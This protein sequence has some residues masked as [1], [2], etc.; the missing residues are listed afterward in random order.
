MPAGK[1][2]IVPTPIGNLADMTYRGVEILRI[3]SLIG[4]EDTR[5]SAILL[6]HYGIT[7][8]MLSY[9]KFNEKSRLEK[10]IQLLSAGK[11]LAIISDAGT[12]GISDPAAIIIRE[13]ILNNYDVCTLP[14]AAAFLPALVSSGFNTEKFFFCGFL[15]A[16]E[17]EQEKLFREIK[18]LT[19]TLIFYE[20]PHRIASFL[21][22]LLANLGDRRIV[23]GRELTKKFE[24][25]YR[26]LLSSFVENPT[27]I[28]QKGEITVICEGASPN[29]AVSDEMIIEALQKQL[30]AGES[31]SF[32]IGKVSNDLN[33][34][35]NRVY[36]L[37][38][39]M[40]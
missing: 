14:G 9:H 16:K 26:E 36:S 30:L 1:L 28:K 15:P 27:L 39:Q 38:H 21:Q 6:K 31:K 10:F 18:E 33:I 37:A 3:V 11:D 19:A 35:K 32:A 20:S 23:I 22:K 34:A 40:G 5:Q 8:P 2:Y 12:P 13:A 29:V 25:Y 4:A 24:T 7:T 17:I